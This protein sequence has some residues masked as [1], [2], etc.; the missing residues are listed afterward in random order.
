MSAAPINESQKSMQ[1]GKKKPM[2]KSNGNPPKMFSK[3][4]YEAWINP[5]QADGSSSGSTPPAARNRNEAY[6][7]VSKTRCLV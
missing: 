1:L 7:T 2:M 4:D 6:E 5:C 3:Q